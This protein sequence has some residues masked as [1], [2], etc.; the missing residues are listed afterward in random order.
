V[1]YGGG[2]ELVVELCIESQIAA[3]DLLVLGS[4]RGTW[5]LLLENFYVRGVFLC[6]IVCTYAR[7]R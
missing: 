1:G 6:D 2:D 4:R 5:V 3:E 7:W